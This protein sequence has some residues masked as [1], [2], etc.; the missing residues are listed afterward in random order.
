M[1]RFWRGVSR[2]RGRRIA[3]YILEA[4]IGES[5]FRL[6]LEE[7]MAAF[8]RSVVRWLRNSSND[9]SD[10]NSVR[11]VVARKTTRILT[12]P[13]SSVMPALAME[14]LVAPVVVFV[15]L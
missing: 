1:G 10:R 2:R 12:V 11:G 14:E 5:I 15:R 7:R 4:N 6:I 9:E 13:E 8:C 3:W